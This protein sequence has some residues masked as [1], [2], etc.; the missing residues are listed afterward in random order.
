MWDHASDGHSTLT[1]QVSTQIQHSVNRSSRCVMTA[2]K[3]PPLHCKTLALLA[4]A[5]CSTLALAQDVGTERLPCTAAA[6]DGYLAM[7][8]ITR[9]SVDLREWVQHYVDL[10]VS[11]VYVFDHNSTTWLSS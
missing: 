7:C 10:G 11:K 4:L 1:L 8:L 6:P 5:A 3:T 9:D 2:I